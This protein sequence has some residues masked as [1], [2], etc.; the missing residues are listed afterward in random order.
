MLLSLTGKLSILICFSMGLVYLM[1]GAVGGNALSV[2]IAALIV[3]PAVSAAF[4][5]ICVTHPLGTLTKAMRLLEQGNSDAKITINGSWEMKALSD[6]FNL[7][8]DRVIVLV[9]STAQQ[10]FDLAQ[11]QERAEHNIKLEAINAELEKTLNEVRLLNAR[12]ETMYLGIIDAMVSTVEA[13]DLYTHGHS[14]RVTSYCLALADR[15]GLPAERIKILKHAATLHD[16]GKVG[17]D[18]SILH[19]PGKLT[20]EEYAVMQQH[21]TIARNILTN[22]DYLADVQDCVVKHHERFDGKGYP[23]GVCGDDLPVEARIMA[24]ADT[25]DAMT[26]HRPYRRGLPVDVAIR[27]LSGNA[28]SQLDPALVESFIALVQEGE[29]SYVSDEK[30]LRQKDESPDRM[31]PGKPQAAR[32][33][34]LVVEDDPLSS[35]MVRDYLTRM[36][37]TVDEA[38]T[39]EAGIKLFSEKHYDLVLL[40]IGLPDYD[41]FTVARGMRQI[42]R[43]SPQCCGMRAVICALTSASEEEAGSNALASGMNL[44][45]QKPF[46]AA[47]MHDIIEMASQ[48]AERNSG[49]IR[50][51]GGV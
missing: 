32:I 36:G 41:G 51:K 19:K 20:D 44:F 7:M 25:F 16:I 23:F 24:V 26:S 14:K 28:G 45:I 5:R 6:S 43:T 30:H 42:E 2:A 10:V 8:V 35:L 31:K 34:A 15:I 12:Q 9:D 3:L 22:I 49:Q 48:V 46:T 40:D 13:S 27:E 21:P 4:I 29:L 50:I 18:K 11:G 33:T 17:I 1:S 39:A 38:I 37:H 47:I